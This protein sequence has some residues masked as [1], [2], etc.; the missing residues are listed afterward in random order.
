MQSGNIFWP[1]QQGGGGERHVRHVGD[2]PDG[3]VKGIKISSRELF[4]TS[5]SLSSSY[6]II[7][8]SFEE[9]YL[10]GALTT[11]IIVCICSVW[12][13]IKCLSTSLCHESCAESVRRWSGYFSHPTDKKTGG[14]WARAWWSLCPEE[15]QSLCSG[16][17]R[18]GGRRLQRRS[19]G[20]TSVLVIPRCHLLGKTALPGK[21]N[22]SK[23]NNCSWNKG[24]V[25]F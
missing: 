6:Y 10:L 23:A 16:Y 8:S 3:Q 2:W 24:W 9:I 21:C 11:I 18:L 22:N 12:K 1:V 14:G 4:P 15:R 20:R 19:S 25:Y 7:A 5:L 13:S 17:E